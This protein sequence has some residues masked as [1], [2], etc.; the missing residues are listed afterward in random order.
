[1]A[2]L[3]ENLHDL[4]LTKQLFHPS[5]KIFKKNRNILKKVEQNSSKFSAI[6]SLTPFQCPKTAYPHQITAIRLAGELIKII[7]VIRYDRNK[8]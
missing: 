3:R 2:K 8:R 4:N 6:M 5:L 1:M 7:Y